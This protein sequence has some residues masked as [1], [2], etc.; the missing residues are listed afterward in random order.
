MK[1]KLN[2]FHTQKLDRTS[3]D[4]SSENS[5]MMWTEDEDSKERSSAWLSNSTAQNKLGVTHRHKFL[6]EVNEMTSPSVKV[7]LR[8]SVSRQKNFS[9]KTL[10]VFTENPVFLQMVGQGLLS[11][12][13]N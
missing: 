12:M 10:K 13:I 2:N 5:L 8:D 3:A 6:N 11:E 1:L 4:C 9:L 7:Q